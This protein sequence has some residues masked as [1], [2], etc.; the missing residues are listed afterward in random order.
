MEAKK[1]HTTMYIS[2]VPMFNFDISGYLIDVMM[3]ASAHHYDFTCRSASEP[4]GFLYGM[5]NMILLDPQGLG[6]CSARL[7]SRD[8]D[9]LMKIC[10]NVSMMNADKYIMIQEFVSTMRCA[11]RQAHDS[12]G[13][14]RH[15][16]T[17]SPVS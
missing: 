11:F 17:T 4:G 12:L 14:W 1:T 16:V 2:A 3:L 5:R 8:A 7:S 6:I 10:E 13:D 15:D 9:T